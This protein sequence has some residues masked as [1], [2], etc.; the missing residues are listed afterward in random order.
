MCTEEKKKNK[1]LLCICHCV[2]NLL[3]CVKILSRY[4]L[5]CQFR[6]EKTVVYLKKKQKLVQ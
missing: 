5:Y 3:L 2:K 6:D 4:V 1:A